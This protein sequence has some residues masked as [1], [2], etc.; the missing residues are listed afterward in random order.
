MQAEEMANM[1]DERQ[2]LEWHLQSNH[3]PPVPLDMVE[4]CLEAIE[5]ANSGD[6]NAGIPLPDGI[7][8][9]EGS[10]APAWAIIEAHHLDP[11]VEEEAW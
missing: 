2:A 11:W 3:F 1:L 6:W 10:W 5:L 8:W 7:T 4:P 9:R